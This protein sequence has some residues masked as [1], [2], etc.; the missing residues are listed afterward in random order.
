MARSTSSFRLGRIFL[1]LLLLL[2]IVLVSALA[3]LLS[4]GAAFLAVWLVALVFGVVGLAVLI[5]LPAA[6]AAIQAAGVPMLM[7]FMGVTVVWPR[8]ASLRL[9]GMPALSVSRLCLLALLILG[10]YIVSKAPAVRQRLFARLVRFKWIF[11]PLLV[12]MFVRIVGIPFSVAPLGS[13]RGLLNELLTI[14]APMLLALAFIETRRDIHRVLWVLLIATVLVLLLALYEYRLG[15]NLFFG[16]LEIDSE[17]L[18]Q[19]LRDKVRAGGYRLQSTFAHPLTLSEFLVIMTPMALYLTVADGF[20]WIRSIGFAVFLAVLA[21]VVIKTGSRSGIGSLAVVLGACAILS[22]ARLS[23]NTRNSIAA[24]LYV[25]AA[26]AFIAVAALGLYLLMDIIV[27]RTSRE[28]NSGM[29]RL[30]MW[31]E[32]LAK[33]ASRPLLGFGQDTAANVLGFVGAQGVVTIDSYFLSVLVD[34]GFISLLMYLLAL[35]VMG[36]TFLRAGLRRDSPDLLA[37]LIAA[38]LIGFVLVKAILSLPHNHG[39]FMTLVAVG[40]AGIAM[41]EP[42]RV[43]TL[44]QPVLARRWAV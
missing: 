6:P 31:Q 21:F 32:G 4:G 36:G 34:G 16:V 20:R 33:V 13:L 29:V 44:T 14:Y 1:F 22:A 28:F 9:P 19:V 18:Q 42:A 17:Y 25:L 3:T 26:I 30:L 27:G 23:R 8:Y 24:A 37:L 12:W 40:L 5:W 15:R 39:L 38:S 7:L 11:Y 2:M 43:A 35:S 41:R 10:I